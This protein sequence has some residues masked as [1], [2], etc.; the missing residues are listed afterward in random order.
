M[1]N[2]SNLNSVQRSRLSHNRRI[3]DSKAFLY[4]ETSLNNTQQRFGHNM[5]ILHD[6]GLHF[7]TQR[8]GTKTRKRPT[9][10][11]IDERL[12]PKSEISKR[13]TLRQHTSV[14]I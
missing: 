8:I 1:A 7:E 5:F 6:T 4:K 12:R 2:V 10:D 14:I 3:S 13:Q 11:P 9:Q